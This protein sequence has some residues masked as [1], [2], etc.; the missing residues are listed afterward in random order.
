MGQTACSERSSRGGPLHWCSAQRKDEVL[1]A[2]TV[3]A[4]RSTAV[5]PA[6]RPPGEQM[7]KTSC[8]KRRVLA[9]VCHHGHAFYHDGHGG[10]AAAAASIRR[11]S[12]RKTA[13]P[14]GTPQPEEAGQPLRVRRWL[15]SG[16]L[17]T[18]T[19]WCSHVWSVLGSSS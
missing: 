11:A 13:P 4:P 17:L 9:H 18:R 1:D 14:R 12:A 19:G 5:L 10:G 16:P 2:V 3:A 7:H 6:C 8:C 15:W